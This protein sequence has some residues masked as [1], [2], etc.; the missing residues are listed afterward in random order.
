M[1]NLVLD[2]MTK[3][4]PRIPLDIPCHTRMERLIKTDILTVTFKWIQN[5]I[6]LK[7]EIFIQMRKI[8]FFFI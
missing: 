8:S 7:N 5:P 2:L 4:I 6:L 3:T 1:E